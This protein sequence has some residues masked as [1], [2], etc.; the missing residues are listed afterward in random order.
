MD[1]AAIAADL[2][3]ALDGGRSVAPL[4]GRLP[5][6]D[7][8]AA[9]RVTAA[10]R[11]LR[12]ARGETVVGR[13][14]GFTNRNIWPEFGVFAPIWGDVFDTSFHE[15][16][17][18]GADFELSA[19]SEPKIEPEIAFGLVRAPEPGM[20]DAALM[21]CVAWV[22]H[23][24]EVVQSLYPGWR[25]QA[26]DTVAG[27]AMHGAYLMGPRVPVAPGETAGWVRMLADFHVTLTRDGKAMDRGHASDV[28]GGPGGGRVRHHR[29]R[30]P[31]AGHRAGRDLADPRRG[32]AAARSPPSVPVAPPVELIRASRN[33]PATQNLHQRERSGRAASF[34]AA[35]SVASPHG[36]S[37]RARPKRAGG[38]RQR[39]G[40]LR[41]NLARVSTPAMH[42]SL[43]A[44]FRRFAAGTGG[45]RTSSP[46]AGKDAEP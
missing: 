12:T 11:R 35:A 40:P 26:P 36:S 18:E 3:A 22:A 46:A 5:G 7:L 32:P 39:A 10:H 19:F 34:P 23:G 31:G 8:A 24:V 27:F 45:D 37:A 42:A 16:A 43:A 13:K 29:H 17:P 33:C 20:D 9:Y 15:I 44:A 30:D 21:S 25:F 41:A 2:L 38:R 14:L 1:T 4:T 28:L 6:F